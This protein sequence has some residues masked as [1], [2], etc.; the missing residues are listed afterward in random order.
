[1]SKIDYNLL[2]IKGI[3]CDVDGVLSPTVVP[4]DANGVPQRMANLKD[5]YA[6]QLAVKKGIRFAIISGA[7]VQ[8]VRNRFSKLGITDIFLGAGM[9]KL[10]ALKKW[11]DDSGLKPDEVAYLG[12][13]IPDLAPMLA[14]GLPVAPRDA[15]IEVRAIARYITAADGGHGVAREVVEQILKAQDL[16]PV[17]AESFGL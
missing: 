14:V 4:M 7:D 3:V 2:K 6:M 8:Q 15:A 16:W 13:D 9:D 12:D 17:T 5:G 1:M 10:E 11:L